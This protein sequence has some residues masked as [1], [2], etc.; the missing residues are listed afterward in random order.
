MPNE[1]VM[2]LP[3]IDHGAVDLFCLTKSLWVVLTNER[4]PPQGQIAAGSRYSLSQQ[5][6]NEPSLDQ[7]DR[8]VAQATSDDPAVR[9]TFGELAS[10]LAAW[11]AARR[12]EGDAPT[13]ADGEE[14][15]LLEEPTPRTLEVPPTEGLLPLSADSPAELEAL[16]V[17]LMRRRDDIGLR[18]LAREERRRLEEVVRAGVVA[19]YGTATYGDVAEFWHEVEPAF[20]RILA[21][22]LPLI[23]HHS[24]LWDDQLRWAARFGETRLL[25][26]GLVMWIEMS[27]WCGWL[28]GTCCGGFAM[29]VDNLDVVGSL[30][31]PVGATI[32]GEPL[33][34]MRA[35][36]SGVNVGMAIMSELDGG[37][38]YLLPHHES[39]LRYLGSMNWLRDRYREF[40]GDQQTLRRNVDDFNFLA[41]LAA[42]V[43]G[44]RVSASWAMSHDGGLELA[45]RIRTSDVFRDQVARAVGTTGEDLKNRGQEML[46]AAAIAPNGFI[47]SNAEL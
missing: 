45:R 37:R 14:V 40:A 28:F 31:T 4:R 23:A 12:G 9:G 47:S 41:T 46:L 33:G 17:E 15:P 2:R 22:T 11:T 26:Q 18:E 20:E 44:G 13:H 16:V 38:R 25:D 29:A 3:N 6:E 7:L 19:K 34:L 24:S 1:A 8:I 43:V 42:A 27:A 10:A 39:T 5:L 21:V 32:D 35:G 36:E 30:L